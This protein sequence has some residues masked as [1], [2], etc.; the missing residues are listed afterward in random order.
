MIDK[1]LRATQQRQSV[2]EAS[3]P[4][5]G[6]IMARHLLAPPEGLQMFVV[7]SDILPHVIHFGRSQRLWASYQLSRVSRGRG[8]RWTLRDRRSGE[9]QSSAVR[10]LW[11]VL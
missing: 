7:E 3:Y 5:Q 2:D 4:G 10:R 1:A 9:S 6:V 11:L 8:R